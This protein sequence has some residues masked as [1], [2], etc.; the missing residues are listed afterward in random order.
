MKTMFLIPARGGSKG[1]PRK[2]IKLLNGKPLIHYAIEAALEV[3]DDPSDICLSTEDQEIIAVAEQAGIEVPF[4]RPC[5]LARDDSGSY[6]V[7]L[8]ALDFYQHKGV[9]YDRVVLLQP[10]SPFRTASHIQ[11]ALKLYQEDCEMVVSVHPAKSNPYFAMFTEGTDGF[12]HKLLPDCFTRRQDCPQVYEYNGAIYVMNAS[13]L[14]QKPLNSFTKC[15]KYVMPAHAS[16][17]LDTPEDWEFCEF[18]MEKRK[19]A[20]K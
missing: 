17:D 15:R 18:L 7:I 3:A 5:E 8:H 16:V 12:L 6:E 2:N 13:V 14:R 4:V 11:E 19:Q 1:I 10:T 20:D 9:Q